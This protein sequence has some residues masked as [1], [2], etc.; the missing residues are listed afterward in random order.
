MTVEKTLAERG[1]RY[2]KFA[3]HARIAQGIQ[4]VMRAHENWNNLDYDMKQALT[5]I[6]DKIARILNGD[7]FY[8]DN[9]HDLQG[10]AKLIEDRINMIPDKDELLYDP[11]AAAIPGVH[12]I[13]NEKKGTWL[14]DNTI[15]GVSISDDADVNHKSKSINITTT[16]ILTGIEPPLSDRDIKNTKVLVN[17]ANKIVTDN[18]VA[19]VNGTTT[20]S[21]YAPQS[22]FMN[23]KHLEY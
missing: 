23:P 16:G 20:R 14:R 6:A 4:D 2:G 19:A 18:S 3:D 21:N 22:V 1:S 17:K 8:V 12:T 13:K 9:W 5:V 15:T 11:P 10:Y 7:P